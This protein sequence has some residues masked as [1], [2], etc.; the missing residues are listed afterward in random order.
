MQNLLFLSL[1]EDKSTTF[2]GL[3]I[4]KEVRGRQTQAGTEAGRDDNSYQSLPNK[5]PF[6]FG[7]SG[8]IKSI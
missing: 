2:L 3:D 8:T 6:Y 7:P 4:V 5:L 1:G